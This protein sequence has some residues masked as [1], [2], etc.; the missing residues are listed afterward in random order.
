MYYPEE[1]VEEVRSKND[2][3][4]IIGSYVKLKKRGANFV[5]LCPF[6]QEKTPSFSVSIT[7]QFYHCFGCGAGGNVF[8]FLMEYESLNFLEAVEQLAE[9]AGVK[10]PEKSSEGEKEKSSVRERLLRLHKDAAAFYYRQLRS[11]KGEPGLRYF[12]SRKLGTQIMRDFGLGYASLDGGLCKVLKAEGY[13]DQE[14]IE[15]GLGKADE[16]AGLRD[17]F[18]NRVIFPIMDVK[19]RVIGF[20]GRVMGEG[21]PKY[22][23]S[24]ETPIFE[25]GKNLYGLNRAAKSRKGYF[26]ACEGYMDVISMHEAGFNE[27]VASL[28][29][30]FTPD[31][32]TL[33]KRYVS[34]VILSYDSDS[35]G[36]KAALRAIPIL[37]AGGLE[38]KV[39]HLDPCKDPDEFLKSRGVDEFRMRIEGAEDSL[40]FEVHFMQEGFDLSK[41]GD[42][43][44]FEESLAK[45]LSQIDSELER[46]N[47]TDSFATEYM[48]RPDALHRLVEQYVLMGP[49]DRT[50]TD[51]AGKEPQSPGLRNRR[52]SDKDSGEILAEKLL[53]AEIVKNPKLYDSIKP[54][55]QPFEF[56][57]GI[58]RLVAELL[59][60]QL[61]S[62]RLSPADII[63]AFQETQD[64]RKVAEIF[65][66]ELDKSLSIHEKEKAITDLVIRIKKNGLMHKLKESQDPIGRALSEKKALEDLSGIS[67]HILG[68]D[69]DG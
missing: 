56:T 53:L 36:K 3:V 59:F 46:S 1:I 17:R 54:Y 15:A 41:P 67:I 55:L 43:T 7:G 58:Y 27:A 21:E 61:E 60:G 5:G 47:Y 25:K 24:P 62:G 37:N 49:T 33:M 4:D 35:A 20:G 38:C 57:E 28:G 19:N 22:L 68:D 42:R 30:A 66:Q 65:S 48:I 9:R 45:R 23:N 50:G 6:H 13:T 18:W 2:I 11:P 10:L 16:K 44:K 34:E 14:I 52:A 64:E 69:A 32:A 31:H 12:M 63:S 39:L 40:L 51:I 8:S 26:I 29:T